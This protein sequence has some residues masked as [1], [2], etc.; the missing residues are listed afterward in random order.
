[1]T[2]LIAF[3]A[4][5]FVHELGHASMSLVLGVKVHR[6]GLCRYGMY[7]KMDLA[8]KIEFYLVTLAGPVTTV[9]FFLLGCAEGWNGFA[10]ANACIMIACFLP[11]GD[12]WRLFQYGCLQSRAKIDRYLM[13]VCKA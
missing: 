5:M 2:S 10:L 1:M 6:I 13:A 7:T 9:C 8:G 12:F 3:L 4:A 11:N